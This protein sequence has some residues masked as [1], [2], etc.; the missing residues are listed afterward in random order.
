[1][2]I[3]FYAGAERTSRA[4]ERSRPA[5]VQY[6]E[7]SLLLQYG[8]P[9]LARKTLL[10]MV[11]T[12]HKHHEGEARCRT[13]A[14]LS[15]IMPPRWEMVSLCPNQAQDFY[16]RRLVE[17]YPSARKGKLA[18]YM[19][20]VRTSSVGIE[21]ALS[22]ARAIYPAGCACARA[23]SDLLPTPAQSHLTPNVNDGPAD[24]GLRDWKK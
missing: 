14:E 7:D 9:S 4:G 15:G 21:D 24:A 17:I 8:M 12:C 5:L 19:C 11:A 2:L 20:S 6:V 10:Q 22:Y 3:R 16:F 23:L 13:F 1:M 18:D